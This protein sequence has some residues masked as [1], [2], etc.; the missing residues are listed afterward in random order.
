V[1]VSAALRSDGTVY[2][3]GDSG[4]YIDGAPVLSDG[5][6]PLPILGLSGVAS[7]S[8]GSGHVLA[9]KPDGTVWGIGRNEHG[10]LGLGFS[11]GFERSV[12][13]VP[14]LSGVV[15][16]AGSYQRS[17]VVHS[18]G[19]VSAFGRG[20]TFFGNAAMLGDGNPADRLSPFRI[21]GLG[22]VA[23]VS[24]TTLDSHTLAL[25]RDGSVVAWG[26][27]F[28]GA[29]GDGTTQSRGTPVRVSGLRDVAAV[30]AGGDFSLAL[31]NGGGGAGW[32][33]NY[34][35]T[36]GDGTF[37]NRLTPIAIAGARGVGFLDLTPATPSG[38]PSEVLPP[39]AVFTT[40]SGSSSAPIV[41]ALVS[42]KP[43]DVGTTGN[44]Y[45]FALAPASSVLPAAGPPDPMMKHLRA[46]ARDGRK[47][48][49]VQCVLAQLT[50]S[51][52]LQQVSASS[53]QAYVSGVLSAQGQAVTVINGVATAQIGGATFFV[54]YGPN[55]T[56]ML[57]GGSNRSVVSL[58]GALEC[59]PAAPQTGWWWNTSEGGRGYSIEVQGNH[60]FYAAF[61]YDDTGRSN[62]FVATGTTT[63]DGSLFVGDLLRVT[64]GQALGGA[65]HPPTPAQSVGPFTL[66]FSDASHA[67]MVWPGGTVAIERF[68][69]VPGGLDAPPRS[70]QPETGW[71]WN[72]AESGRGFFIEWQDGTADLAGY[73]YDDS[74]NAVWYLSVY[75]TPDIRA[76]N[77]NWWLYANGQS[78]TSPYRPATRIND[79]VAPVTIQFTSATTATLNL[80]NGRTTQLQRHRF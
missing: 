3:W 65:Y 48:T 51:G 24:S 30:S 41:N 73:M 21:P 28:L 2:L 18:D 55:A 33:Y 25:K 57:N 36:A 19:T 13:Q 26:F 69:I 31:F 75:Q 14:G 43:A 61:L 9:V 79:N 20:N 68:N 35:G 12:R 50:A 4:Q 49:P 7:I 16:A 72:P 71:W 47:D 66:A 38:L 67:T 22:D 60:I 56:T 10:Q 78:L 52:Q 44:V 76:F 15:S 5:S 29:L 17:F 6:T 34:N 80:P 42:F 63:L 77:G 32:G 11:S 54:G 64:G 8:S 39:F 23:Q 46:T 27:V 70:N 1:N 62:W 58:P 53:L 74:G 59:K 45:V 37:S 40:A